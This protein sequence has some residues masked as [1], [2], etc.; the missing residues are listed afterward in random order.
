MRPI[1]PRAAGARASLETL[2]LVFDL[3][4][5]CQWG[6]QWCETDRG[7][8]EDEPRRDGREA[9]QPGHLA[10]VPGWAGT[11]HVRQPTQAARQPGTQ[12]GSRPGNEGS[13]I[14]RRGRSPDAGPPA[15]SPAGPLPRSGR[16][17]LESLPVP[18]LAAGQ[19]GPPC[20]GR[21]T[22]WPS[23]PGLPGCL[24]ARPQRPPG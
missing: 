19:T 2:R 3:T 1:S 17:G 7:N 5:M 6:G 20:H 16:N 23:L 21:L 10:A 18:P 4:P 8:G 13:Q 14:S 12:P 11:K 24:V 9:L 22:A 15:R